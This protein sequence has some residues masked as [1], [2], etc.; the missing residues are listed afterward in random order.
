ME[1][2]QMEHDNS[3]ESRI[4]DSI[5]RRVCNDIER[6]IRNLENGLVGDEF[7]LDELKDLLDEP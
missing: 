6:S 4:D 1:E 3:G 5:S 7:E 2:H